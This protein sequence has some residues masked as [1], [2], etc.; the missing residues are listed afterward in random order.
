[1]KALGG[2]NPPSS[3]EIDRN[4]GEKMAPHRHYWNN[5]YQ[6]TSVNPPPSQFAAFVAGEELEAGD[7]AIL[8]IGCGNGRDAVLLSRDFRSYTGLDRSPESIRRCQD[9]S[10]KRSS[11]FILDIGEAV[12]SAAKEVW[13]KKDH[14]DVIY[15][16]FFIHSISEEQETFFLEFVSRVLSPGG[17]LYVEYRTTED[18]ALPKETD[19]HYRRFIEPELLVKTASNHGLELVYGIEGRGYAKYGKDDAHVARQ[20]FI[21]RG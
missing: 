21:K 9:L 18:K 3:A 19:D 1:V 12:S 5:F 11:F 7:L 17:R 4:P 6:K 16:R 15:A 8:E 13:E 20:V 14:F 10:L 2:S